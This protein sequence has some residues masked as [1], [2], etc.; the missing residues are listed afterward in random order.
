MLEKAK[1]WKSAAVAAMAVM[2]AP[3]AEAT[4]IAD[5]QLVEFCDNAGSNC[6]SLSQD[7]Q[8]A[9]NAIWGQADIQFNFLAPV[10]ENN[11]GLLNSQDFANVLV[12]LRAL[13]EANGFAAEFV[14]GL[15]A[16]DGTSFRG[17]AFLG[18]AP[19][20]GFGETGISAIETNV[21]SADEEGITLAH[22]FGHNLGLVHRDLAPTNLMAPVLF[23]I[24]ST[25][26]TLLPDQIATAQQSS[27]LRLQPTVPVSAPPTALLLAFG[28]LSLGASRWRMRAASRECSGKRV[29]SSTPP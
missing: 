27:L 20:S 18:P 3:A 10:Q 24:P 14:V 9:V 28:V 11:S 8:T 6:T 29:D 25:E 12:A 13:T 16:D 26:V 1:V 17:L 15:I 2:A 4:F 23:A 7:S 5:V 19:R 22:M 21:H